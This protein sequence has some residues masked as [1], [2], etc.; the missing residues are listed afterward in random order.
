MD[1]QMI[2]Q[3]IIG[4]FKENYRRIQKDFEIDR[5]YSEYKH[6]HCLDYF[7]METDIVINSKY[8]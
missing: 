5:V 8:K 4:E 6:Q 3:I 7:A 2:R 1:P